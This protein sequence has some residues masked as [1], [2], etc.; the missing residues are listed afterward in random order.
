MQ[1]DVFTCKNE[2]QERNPT[3]RGRD[4]HFLEKNNTALLRPSHAALSITTHCI[5]QH[6]TV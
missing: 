3:E 2:R 4:S 1:E 5:P 6:F